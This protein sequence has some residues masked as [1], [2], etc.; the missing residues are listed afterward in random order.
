MKNKKIKAMS[1]SELQ[2]RLDIW[3]SVLEYLKNSLSFPPFR[4][5][6]ICWG[7]DEYFRSHPYIPKRRHGLKWSYPEMWKYHPHT[8]RQSAVWWWKPTGMR[9]RLTRIK[10]VECII[11][12][13][14]EEIKSRS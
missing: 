14:Q 8:E 6:C 3:L 5:I 11:R 10:T 13:L 4:M 1:L 2:M 9:G 12:D 7:I